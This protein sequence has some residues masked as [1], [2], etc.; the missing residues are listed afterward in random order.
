MSK[1]VIFTCSLL[2]LLGLWGGYETTASFARGVWYFNLLALFLPVAIALFMALPGARIAATVVFSILYLSLALFLALFL[3]GISMR[4][5]SMPNVTVQILR[6]DLPLANPYP[7]VLVLAVMFACVLAL[8][9]WM[10]YSPPFDEH[11]G[12]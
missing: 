10:L 8:L 5:I 4:H 2:L 6:S 3:A 11:L 7:F 12:A 9:H 1:R